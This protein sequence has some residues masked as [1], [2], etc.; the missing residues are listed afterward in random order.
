MNEHLPQKDERD[1]FRV[2]KIATAL[3][4]GGMAAFLYSLKQVHPDIRFQFTA[5]TILIFFAVAV[6][7]W[8]FCGVLAKSESADGQPA[9]RKRF[10]IRWLVSF[11]G[12]TTLATAASFVYALKN[13]EWARRREVIEGTLLA[14]AVLSLGGLLVWKAFRFFEQ[15]SEAELAE[16]HA[17]EQDSED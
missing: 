17:N 5:G 12:I 2:V 7:S 9:N 11:I 15:Q 10:V 4:M 3:G 14:F 8:M 1:F 16:R 13:V 6:F